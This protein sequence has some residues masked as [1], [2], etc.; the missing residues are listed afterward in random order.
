MHLTFSTFDTL[1]HRL[2]VDSTDKLATKLLYDASDCL[3]KHHHKAFM[4]SF[5]ANAITPP[6]LLSLSAELC[7]SRSNNRSKRNFSLKFLLC[8]SLI[9]RP[10]QPNT[11]FLFGNNAISTTA[12]GVVG[13]EDVTEA[14]YRSSGGFSAQKLLPGEVV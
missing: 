13:W 14:F 11:C 1:R 8:T 9:T 12:N 6:P 4:L 3:W 2:W 5:K 10:V 7:C